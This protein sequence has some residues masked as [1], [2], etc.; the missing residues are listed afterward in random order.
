MRRKPLGAPPT[1]RPLPPEQPAGSPG[2]ATGKGGRHFKKSRHAFGQGH[3]TLYTLIEQLGVILS[4]LGRVCGP[5][6][7]P[8]QLLC[9]ATMTRVCATRQS[10]LTNAGGP[11]GWRTMGD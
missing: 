11:A 5:V 7:A 10:P 1:A 9:L 8:E 4:R 6:S 2:Q 3:F